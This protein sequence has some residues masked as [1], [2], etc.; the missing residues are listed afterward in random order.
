M[1]YNQLIRDDW[2]QERVTFLDFSLTC[3][4]HKNLSELIGWIWT[5]LQSKSQLDY[6]TFIRDRSMPDNEVFV[7]LLGGLIEYDKL[8]ITEPTS[9]KKGESNCFFIHERQY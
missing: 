8:R 1:T 5:D 3:E 6:M 7:A 4:E 2:T 9:F